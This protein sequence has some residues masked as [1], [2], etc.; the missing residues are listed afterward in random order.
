[1]TNKLSYELLD[2][3]A[4]SFN[5]NDVDAI[6]AHFLEDGVFVNGKGPAKTGEIYTGK[7]EIRAFFVGLFKETPSIRWNIIRPYLIDGDLAVTNWHRVAVDPQGATREWLGC[8]IYK[9][10]GDLIRKKDTYVKLV[11]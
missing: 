6:V 5:S 4:D 3:I 11:T 2:R 8:D 7:D 1:M 9:F 10:E